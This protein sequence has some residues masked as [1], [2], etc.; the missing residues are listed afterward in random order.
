MASS[1][2]SDDSTTG[3]E[4]TIAMVRPDDTTFTMT[5]H[6]QAEVIHAEFRGSTWCYTLR[7]ASGSTVQ[8]LRSHLDRVDVGTRVE[9]AMR[10]GHHPVPI[11]D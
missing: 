2:A 5:P 10:P 9:V 1:D 7:L 3:G 6:G 4:T 11:R 8:S